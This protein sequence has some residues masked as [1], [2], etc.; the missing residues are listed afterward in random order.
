MQY[1][2]GPATN[3]VPDLLNFRKLYR[4]LFEYLQMNPL[5][6]PFITNNRILLHL[7]SADSVSVIKDIASKGSEAVVAVI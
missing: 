1:G 2:E 4:T 6:L 3:Y 5:Y 7:K